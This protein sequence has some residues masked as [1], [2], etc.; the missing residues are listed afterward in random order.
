MQASIADTSPPPIGIFELND[1][2]DNGTNNA[3]QDDIEDLLSGDPGGNDD[4]E[5]VEP[6][7]DD[8]EETGDTTTTS[9]L[10]NSRTSMPIWLTGKYK[11]LLEQL[12]QE[13]NS[14][15][16]R[17]P[18][19]YDHNQFTITPKN[20]IFAAAHQAQPSLTLFCEPE[21]FIWLPHLFS[22]IPCPACKASNRQT[23]N[24]NTIMLR[25][26]G[27]PNAPR[28]VVDIEYTS[29]IVGY[30]Y[31]CAQCR[32]TY[33]SWSPAIFH[34][35]APSLASQFTF[36]LTYRCGVTSHLMAYLRA[37]FQRGVGPTPFAE[38]IQT[39][40]IHRY[41]QLASLYYELIALRLNSLLQL[42]GQLPKHQHF[43]AW[44]DRGGYASYV[45]SG[46][47]FGGLYNLFIESHS[48]EIDQHMA[49]LS[50]RIL[51][52]DHSFKAELER[53]FSCLHNNVEPIPVASSLPHLTIP[54]DLQ[55]TILET[56]FTITSCLNYLMEALQ[57][58]P[59]NQ[60]L[61]VAMDME[62]S[63][64][65]T[66]GYQGRVALVSIAFSKTIYL[67]LSYKGS[68]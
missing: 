44:N 35:L 67:I 59:K 18:S 46:R 60:C 3:Q 55:P 53:I 12:K 11:D 48:N 64:D 38:M 51:T 63:V 31:Q 20:P 49:M 7:P 52:I 26:H 1:D 47:Y 6:L 14:N 39:F 29:Y 61:D 17:Q 2:I 33:Q 45:P 30:R 19:C 23:T 50:C 22:T 16:S 36:Q 57:G 27:W 54:S 58:L 10:S 15:S 40:H 4:T 25:C 42:W 13:I 34:V 24:G 21:W 56:P 68:C 66:E 65:K 43:G 9:P 8:D 41:E 5:D 28:R 37:C 32:K 62:W